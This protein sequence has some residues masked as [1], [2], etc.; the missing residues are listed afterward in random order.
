MVRVGG[1]AFFEA[2]LRPDC[3]PGQLL[4]R[5][6]PRAFNCRGHWLDVTTWRRVGNAV[7]PVD[8]AFRGD[9]EG[10]LGVSCATVAG[11]TVYL[12]IHSIVGYTFRVPRGWHLPPWDALSVVH[13]AGTAVVKDLRHYDSRTHCLEVWTKRRHDLHH[14]AEGG[15]ARGRGYPWGAVGYW[16]VVGAR[17]GASTEKRRGA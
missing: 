6:E 9:G 13:H 2:V 8:L 1:E 3:V 4:L 17:R 15:R 11:G 14:A 5:Q 12:M 16:G 10:S 7:V